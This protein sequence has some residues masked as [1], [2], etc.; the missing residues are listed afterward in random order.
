MA[1]YNN[2]TDD[3]VLDY[4]ADTDTVVVSNT[5]QDV[6]IRTGTY[7]D[8]I[9]NSGSKASIKSASGNDSIINSGVKS[10]IDGGSGNDYVNNSAAEVYIDTG[11]GDDT[12]NIASGTS[13]LTIDSGTGNDSIINAGS[14]SEINAGAGE[15][16]I[17][18]KNTDNTVTG[19]TSND[20]FVYAESNSELIITDYN[21]NDAINEDDVFQMDVGSVYISS[22]NTV[23]DDVIITTSGSKTITLAGAADKARLHFRNGINDTVISS[24][25]SKEITTGDGN[26]SL[27][28]SG[29]GNTLKV[30]AG[31]NTVISSASDNSI[32]GGSGD[33]YV[34]VAAANNDVNLGSGNNTLISSGASLSATLGG[35]NDSVSITGAETEIDVGDG[36]NTIVSSGR[37]S[38][39]K[40]GSGNDF[41][42]VSGT[43]TDVS[44]GDGKDIISVSAA[45]VS[46]NAGIG[47]DEIV[48]SSYEV[49]ISGG[50]GSDKVTLNSYDVYQYTSGEDVIVNYDATD[51]IQVLGDKNLDDIIKKENIEVS[52]D[53]VKISVDGSGNVITIK[54]GKDKRINIKDKNGNISGFEL[55]G[56]DN[57]V[58]TTTYIAGQGGTYTGNSGS[59]YFV[60]QASADKNT[61]KPGGG[62]DKVIFEHDSVT[63][64]SG[65]YVIVDSGDDVIE[66]IGELDIVVF[67]DTSV[68]EATLG[69]SINSSDLVFNYGDGTVKV[70]KPGKTEVTARLLNHGD[71]A[72]YSSGKAT[73]YGHDNIAD[74]FVF[75]GADASV[76]VEVSG[77]NQDSDTIR[78][79][80]NVTSVSAAVKNSTL[81]LTNNKTTF[82]VDNVSSQKV[83]IIDAT[84]HSYGRQ[85][86]GGTSIKVGTDDGDTVNT[87]LNTTVVT[88]DAS[89]RTTDVMLRGN[90]KS[91]VIYGAG[92]NSTDSGTT[93]HNTIWGAGG[94]DTLYGGKKSD[95][96]M[97][98]AGKDVI[99]NY[100][101]FAVWDT[102]FAANGKGGSVQ[103]SDT[104]VIYISDGSISTYAVTGNDVNFTIGSDKSKVLTVKNGKNRYIEFVTLNGSGEFASDTTWSKIYRSDT[105]FVVTNK[106]VATLTGTPPTVT[107]TAS[108]VKLIDA[109]L[110]YTNTDVSLYLLGN[111]AAN[112][113]Y[114]SNGKGDTLYGG[115]DTKADYLKG[116]SGSDTFIYG[117]G[118]GNDVIVNYEE[119]KDAIQFLD[120]D[121]SIASSSIVT[122]NGNVSFVITNSKGKLKYT[123]KVQDVK[124]KRIT[125]KNP[126]GSIFTSQVFGNTQLTLQDSDLT[127][128]GTS[129][130]TLDT[131]FNTSV[132]NIDGSK[133]TVGKYLIGN[134]KNNSIIGGSGNDTLRGGSGNKDSLTG[135]NGND[136]FAFG[137]N[138]GDN[139]VITDYTSGQDVIKVINGALSSVTTI[140]NSNDLTLTIG[141]TKV[142]LKNKDN[143]KGK[144][145]IEDSVG[146]QTTQV[147]GV[148]S[149]GVYNGDGATIN[150]TANSTVVT[151]NADEHVTLSGVAHDNTRTESVHIVGNKKANVIVTGKGN[152][153]VA[154][155]AGADTVRITGYSGN[156]L[157]ITDYTAGSD[158]IELTSGTTILAA[159]T[160]SGGNKFT[161]NAWDTLAADAVLLTLQ[162]AEGLSSL[163]IEGS[164]KTNKKGNKVYNK[165]TIIDRTTGA[166]YKQAF[167][168]DSIAVANG[169]GDTIDVTGNSKVKIVN[170]K[171][172]T[173]KVVIV[174][175]ELANE[176]TG[177]TKADTI[178]AGSTTKNNGTKINGAGGA[179]LLIGYDTDYAVSLSGGGG[180]DTLIAGNASK[181]ENNTLTGGGGADVFYLSAKYTGSDII[182]DYKAGTDKLY[183][184]AGSS[185]V[186]AATQ[187]GDTYLT[188]QA[189]TS[190]GTTKTLDTS[191]SKIIRI[192]NTANKK[193]TVIDDNDTVTTSQAYG[194]AS[195][196][197]ANADG[198]TI[199]AT[200]V[201][202]KDVVQIMNA[203][204]RSKAV[205]L[206]GNDLNNTIVGGTKADTIVSGKG[207]NSLKGGNGNDVFVY[208]GGDD[209]IADYKNT[210]GNIDSITLA[211]GLSFDTYVVN[212]KDV[213]FQ[214]T[215]S[216]GAN[217][218][219]FT[220]LNGK[221][222]KIIVNNSEKTYYDY[223]EKVFT[224]STSAG[225]YD[226][227]ADVVLINAA[228][229]T[230]AIRITG[231]AKDNS[232]LGG[233]KA[234]T[235][236]GES[237]NNTLTGGSGKDVFIYKGLGNDTI[238]DFT[239]GTDSIKLEGA[240]TLTNAEWSGADLIFKGITALGG[241]EKTL[242]LL[243]I[244]KKKRVKVSITDQQNNTIN[245]IYGESDVTIGNTDGDKI[246]AT[247]SLMGGLKSVDAS[248][249]TAKYPIYII[250]NTNTSVLKSGKG[251]D[252][253]QGAGGTYTPGAGND[254]I[255]LDSGTRTAAV[256]VYSKGNDEVTNFK[257]S[258]TIELTTKMKAT[259]TRSSA[260]DYTLTIKQSGKNLGTL[261][262]KGIT[263][264]SFDTTAEV[265]RLDKTKS[266]EIT[267]TG[268]STVQT[269]YYDYRITSYVTIGGQKVQY[270]TETKTHQATQ[271]EAIAK[272]YEERN[273][274]AS[275][276]ELFAD[277][278]VMNSNDLSTIL[279][280][281]A[282][283]IALTTDKNY[284]TSTDINDLTKLTTTS[285][286]KKRQDE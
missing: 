125:F 256:V 225:S 150:T 56:T 232:I 63:A 202:N 146:A 134:S 74:T 105:E 96:F 270:Y 15:D 279:D 95:V 199:N 239:T 260:N 175:N 133:L 101:G 21:D 138:D 285:T 278:V 244:G 236:S 249:R 242:R 219:L 258:D 255:I 22:F 257:K 144:V 240:V 117:A 211:S 151:I 221:D 187:S 210:K 192:Q 48:V 128:L 280:N 13:S 110:E 119:G 85:I 286:L 44:T 184:E 118:K 208:G 220:V 103:A 135:G 233:A 107:A 272:T 252:T 45:T 164:I 174:G 11:D 97:Y 191:K 283:S 126:D 116:G 122:S 106:D 47:D 155:A 169:D 139:N 168:V 172:R 241:A 24:L 39:I 9:T 90:G 88:V 222:K 99:A 177:S 65:N 83:E 52:G 104:D 245:M 131:T 78:L 259:A 282:S 33:D 27:I 28:I 148:D 93:A 58:V 113:I 154:T 2:I 275:Y 193:L 276:D 247:T 200:S 237:G 243:D 254:K 224:K 156:N 223:Y 108:T 228:K 230:T 76:N 137:K 72:F 205:Y 178:Y 115:D 1:T 5:G 79:A 86:Y 181:G 197:V 40:T 160:L 32:I 281:D 152:E 60:V 25:N 34:S 201:V 114:A 94:A 263:G 129:F 136:F 23:G 54:E 209:T 59:D 180:V 185:I 264:E 61:I 231:N 80:S 20:V 19:G 75:A 188:L 109:S 266:T 149:I 143:I 87:A 82:S 246:D 50:S 176:I 234:D 207:K 261:H 92:Y 100:S 67:S 277:D 147:Y 57:T 18:V 142:R 186:A 238:T 68:P 229:N 179:D 55:V 84:D 182:T 215:V 120:S 42:T 214:K 49:T 145:T 3:Q 196:G 194:T 30:G 190:N 235:L 171:K 36:V 111:A 8:T 218:N 170:A 89:E 227:D 91:N 157:L 173:K 262:I 248:K 162:S 183:L 273:D 112:S 123:L 26:D 38:F 159:S 166:E 204:K 41:V 167:G 124:D 62:N 206:I 140:K 189:F 12:I 165:L 132:K 198:A 158:K 51:T 127:V 153:T 274:F 226:A 37:D 69:A 265:K 17:I 98:S 213:V 271:P 73:L 130:D 251:D 253:L 6:T 46:V 10:T 29:S 71:S 161:S 284:S 31:N 195:L 268:S 212:G 16:T 4:S 43:G 217:K 53:D 102:V 7:D 216:G 35:G 81:T 66:G 250:G 14:R 203:N 269:V 77:Y 163:A 121:I 64:Y 70:V 267:G 141:K